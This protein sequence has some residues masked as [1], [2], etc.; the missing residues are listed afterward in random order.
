MLEVDVH[1]TADKQVVVCH[2]NNLS[3]VAGV[4]CKISDLNYEVLTDISL[5]NL[6][7]CVIMTNTHHYT[8]TSTSHH[9]SAA[10]EFDK[11]CMVQA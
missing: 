3:R 5:Q 9:L 7:N 8:Y 10:V 1:M 11:R 6:Q 2:D 4:D